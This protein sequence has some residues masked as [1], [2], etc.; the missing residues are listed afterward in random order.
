MDSSRRSEADDD[1]VDDD[2][3]SRLRGEDGGERKDVVGGSG[4]LTRRISLEEPTGC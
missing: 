1:E 2:V 3:V 4:K